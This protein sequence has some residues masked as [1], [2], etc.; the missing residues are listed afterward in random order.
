MGN[1]ENLR[2]ERRHNRIRGREAILFSSLLL[3]FLFFFPFFFF[4]SI[5]VDSI[6]YIYIYMCDEMKA[7]Y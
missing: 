7:M 3:S 5:T 2:S 6:R 1:Y 4:F